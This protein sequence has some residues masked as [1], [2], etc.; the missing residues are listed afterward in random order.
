MVRSTLLCL[1]TTVVQVAQAATTPLPAM[2]YLEAV[3][4]GAELFTSGLKISVRIL[5]KALQQ[6]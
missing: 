2:V 1:I 6:S 4:T 5:L 3:L